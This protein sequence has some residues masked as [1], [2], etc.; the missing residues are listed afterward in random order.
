[1]D[2]DVVKT[3]QDLALNMKVHR[4]TFQ[5]N[6]FVISAMT[7]NTEHSVVLANLALYL[8]QS[9]ER[10]LLIDA[11]LREPR[12]H[13]LFRHELDY[14]N[15]LIEL[16]NS[17]SECLFRKKEVYA[18][19][20]LPLIQQVATPSQAYSQLD[21]INA[22]L[23]MEQTFEFLNSKGFSTLIRTAKLAY[24][25]VFIDSPPFLEEPDGAIL[26]S[27]AD[28]LLPFVESDVTQTQLFALK[29]KISKLHANIPGIILKQDN[30]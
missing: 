21:Y 22:G 18:D 27:Y 4:D 7:T 25:W 26:L 6:V 19:D 17:I 23:A 12:L 11:N 3:Y 20:I 16:I 28:G 8:A 15:G 5:E 24:D 1:M 30:E 13:Y 29:N 10:I 9:G 2:Y 14:E